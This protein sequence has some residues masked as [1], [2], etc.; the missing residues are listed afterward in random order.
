M[1]PL[2]GPIDDLNTKNIDWIITGGESGLGARPIEKSWVLDIQRICKKSKTPFF[3]KPWGKKEFN[4]NK[5]D[6]AID[7][8]SVDHAKGGCQLDGVVYKAMPAQLELV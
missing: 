7:A 6:P 8:K 2:L 1:E 5:E 4:V 3:F